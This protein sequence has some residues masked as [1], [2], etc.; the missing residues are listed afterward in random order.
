[1]SFDCRDWEFWGQLTIRH[2]FWFVNGMYLLFSWAIEKQESSQSIRYKGLISFWRVDLVTSPKALSSET[3]TS[4]I[5]IS[6]VKWGWGP[7][8]LDLSRQMRLGE[9][10]WRVYSWERGEAWGSRQLTWKRWKEQRVWRNADGSVVPWGRHKDC[11]SGLE[12]RSH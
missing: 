3:T 2:V 9:V 1:M 12:S 6:F 7:K 4:D 11:S 8:H 5:R 10:K